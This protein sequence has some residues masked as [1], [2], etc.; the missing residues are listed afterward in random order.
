MYIY[1]YTLIQIIQIMHDF[2]KK[3]YDNNKLKDIKSMKREN[4]FKQIEDSI[5]YHDFKYALNMCNYL[6]NSVNLFFVDLKNQC[7]IEYSFVLLQYL[8]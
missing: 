4:I 1:K 6:I 3:Q 2:G 5:L 8:F 7:L